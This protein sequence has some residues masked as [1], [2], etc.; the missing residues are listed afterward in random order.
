MSQDFLISMYQ[1]LRSILLGS[2]FEVN[3]RISGPGSKEKLFFTARKLAPLEL[4]KARL[5]TPT[6]F[7]KEKKS[8]KF[9]ISVHHTF[10]FERFSDFTI[11][12]AKPKMS[13]S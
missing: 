7:L 1:I 13:I 8:K 3:D 9:D 5:W 12:L 6:Y 11:F 4:S 2:N 10:D